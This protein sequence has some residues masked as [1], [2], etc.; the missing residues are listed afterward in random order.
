MKSQL[1]T[2]YCDGVDMTIGWRVVREGYL[3][4]RNRRREGRD[5]LAGDDKWSTTAFWGEVVE[6]LTGASK[7]VTE[8]LKQIRA[9]GTSPVEA[10]QRRPAGSTGLFES[11]ATSVD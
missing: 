11:S 6:P 4:V 3:G 10:I 2:F 9:K 8:V 5:S 1:T 7:D